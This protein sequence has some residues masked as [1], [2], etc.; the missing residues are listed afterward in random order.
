[1]HV[2]SWSNDEN[3]HG[4]DE[5]SMEEPATPKLAQVSGERFAS[6]W[7]ALPSDF[8]LKDQVPAGEF[9]APNYMND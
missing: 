4:N 1:M 8:M 6:M 9:E 2:N 5:S 3:T 7:E